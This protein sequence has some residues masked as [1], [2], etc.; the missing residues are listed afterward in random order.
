MMAHEDQLAQI[1]TL[2]KQEMRLL[3]GLRSQQLVNKDDRI[4][5]PLKGLAQAKIIKIS[6]ILLWLLNMTI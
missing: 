4:Y 2:C 6:V 1:T 3:Y 5:F